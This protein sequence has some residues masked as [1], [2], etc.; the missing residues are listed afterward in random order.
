LLHIPK[1][2]KLSLYSLIYFPK[3]GLTE[4]ALKQNLITRDDIEDRRQRVLSQFRVTLGYKREKWDT[5][6]IALLLLSGTQYIPRQMVSFL[7]RIKL[8]RIYPYPLIML[9]EIVKGIQW[10]QKTVQMAVSGQ[11][12]L[13]LIKRFIVRGRNKQ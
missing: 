7:A 1:P 10:I 2:F 12:T 5:A 3:T 4:M 11:I 9:V 13:S 8:L 6:W